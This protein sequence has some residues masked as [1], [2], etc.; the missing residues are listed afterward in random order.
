MRCTATYPLSSVL[1]L[2]SSLSRLVGE[3]AFCYTVAMNRLSLNVACAAAIL[4][5]AAHGAFIP[6]TN[7]W[8]GVNLHP[9]YKGATGTL[10]RVENGWNIHYDF[11]GGGHGMGM[12]VAPKSPI[13]ARSIAFDA[14]HG[15]GHA[16]CL[17]MTDSAGQTFR[18]VARPAPN[19]WHRFVC[20]TRTG[21]GLHWGGPGDGEIRFPVRSFEINID[22]FAKGSPGPTEIGDVQVKNIAYEEFSPEERVQN[23]RYA[24][25][26]G[27][28]YT[29]TDF[30]PGD[31][32]SAGPRA[33]YRG[34]F[35]GNDGH[36]LA[37][38]TLEV[39]FA[40]EARLSIFN[41]IPIW[42]RPEEFLLTVEAPAE[43]A[44]AEFRL[45]VRMGKPLVFNSFGKLRKPVPGRSRIYQTLSMPG[46]G[47]ALG[48][49][50]PKKGAPGLAPSK[51]V[52]RIEV[53]RG[54]APARKFAF[55]LVRLEAVVPTWF[56]SVQAVPLLATPPTDATPPRQL[57]VG[58]LNLK[59]E[60]R[61]GG[62]IRVRLRDWEGRDLGRPQLRLVRQRLL[63][64]RPTGRRHSAG[65]RL[66]DA[67]PSRRRLAR[68]ASRTA[69][70]HGH[71]H[72]PQRRP[73]RVRL[74][75]HQPHERGGARAHG[76]ARRARAGRRRQVGTRRDQALADRLRQGEVRLLLL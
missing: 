66:L 1:C 2:L 18:K 51:R 29:I 36:A 14:R 75:L 39:D 61:R 65:K 76:A 74:R 72:P 27:V 26:P 59:P 31:Q 22:R 55:R 19:D 63:R 42:G 40:R 45:G 16:I 21:W 56:G 70:G 4:T 62:E 44:G 68:E 48:W 46:P 33:F 17:L 57:T 7:A 25:L 11:T 49:G 71:L 5:T 52:M 3:I 15:N 53:A 8:T 50:T 28:R 20:D 64:E 9:E 24:G 10:T 38:G 13:W 30:T 43:A 41:E 37:D 47:N 23:A 69:V 12:S 34:D 35:A 54:D 60:T 58:Y 67:S 32:F 73:L 6:I